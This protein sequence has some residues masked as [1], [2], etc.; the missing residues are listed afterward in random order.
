MCFHSLSQYFA[1]WWDARW[2]KFAKLVWILHTHFLL[3]SILL[4][5][6]S[7]FKVSQIHCNSKTGNEKGKQP[8]GKRQK[9]EKWC[10]RVWES[11]GNQ[12][13]QSKSAISC[14]HTQRLT[15]LLILPQQSANF[16]LHQHLMT[17]LKW[18]LCEIYCATD[19]II[20]QPAVCARLRSRYQLSQSTYNCWPFSVRCCNFLPPKHFFSPICPIPRSLSVIIAQRRR[21]MHQC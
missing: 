20:L 7:V 16:P 8:E 10:L 14:S 11:S 15:F 17:A 19:P 6:N 21:K 4:T 12:W 1:A 18:S 2:D 5:V 3:I 13:P 9:R